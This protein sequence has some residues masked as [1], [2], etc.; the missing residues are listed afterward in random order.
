[1]S[2]FQK[3][4]IVREYLQFTLTRRFCSLYESGHTTLYRMFQTRKEI[5]IEKIQSIPI[6]KKLVVQNIRVCL[7][8]F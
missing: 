2:G 5:V 4:H 3:G 1:M 7:G 6:Y 8:K